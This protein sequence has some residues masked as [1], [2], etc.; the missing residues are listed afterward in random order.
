MFFPFCTHQILWPK[1]NAISVKMKLELL[2][3]SGIYLFITPER[4]GFLYVR[5][6]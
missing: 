5:I 4:N 6:A 2:L 1:R 3:G